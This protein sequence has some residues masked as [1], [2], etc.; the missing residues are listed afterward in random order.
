MAEGDEDYSTAFPH[1]VAAM[2]T[3][4]DHAERLV[5]LEALIG[6]FA[7]EQRVRS[8]ELCRDEIPPR[9]RDLHDGIVARS[10][11]AIAVDERY[12]LAALF[13]YLDD[14]PLTP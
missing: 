10:P 4:L 8:G 7:L 1:T 3:L 12:D 13:A 5:A 6:S 14:E 2:G 11:M 9:L